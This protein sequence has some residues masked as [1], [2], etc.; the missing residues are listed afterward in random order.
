MPRATGPEHAERL[1]TA[2]RISRR[3]AHRYVAQA[4]RLKAPVPAVDS[5]VA[6]TVK[7]SEVLVDRLHRC[8]ATTG[9]TLSEI[10]SRALWA[11]LRR[12]GGHG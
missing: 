10:V 4:R 11:L 2:A 8:A 12:G 6:F 5:K 3:Q 7:L 9:D 1:G